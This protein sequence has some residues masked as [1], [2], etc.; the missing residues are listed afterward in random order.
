M[1]RLGCFDKKHIISFQDLL[2][3]RWFLCPRG[4]EDKEYIHISGWSGD[5]EGKVIISTWL[6]SWLSWYLFWLFSQPFWLSSRQYWLQYPHVIYDYPHGNA[7]NSLTIMIILMII[8][9][10]LMFY[11]LPFLI[12]M[13]RPRTF[14]NSVSGN[15]FLIT[16]IPF[17]I[18][19]HNLNWS[20]VWHK[21]D[22]PNH[23]PTSPQKLNGRLQECQMN[24]IHHKNKN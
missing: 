14:L 15:S 8:L 2:C 6:L 13:V 18:F 1:L 16:C 11:N 10:I 4:I 24:F 21:N 3:S 17:Q 5:R 9:I 12:Y 22:Q 19:Q 7:N 20:R 23:P